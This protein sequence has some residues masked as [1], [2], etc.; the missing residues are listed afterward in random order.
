MA[1]V[2]VV[3]VTDPDWLVV[4][5]WLPSYYRW[6]PVCLYCRI[7]KPK[8][9]RLPKSAIVIFSLTGGLIVWE[10]SWTDSKATECIS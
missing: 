8:G 6:V 1:Q 2:A 9:V 5:E 10:N 4:V 3:S 7:Q